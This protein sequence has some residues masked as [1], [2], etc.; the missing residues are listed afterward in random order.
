MP[1]AAM[2]CGIGEIWWRRLRNRRF[3]EM[4]EEESSVGFISLDLISVFKSSLFLVLSKS[5]CNRIFISFSES[6][7]IDNDKT[8]LIHFVFSFS[9]LQITLFVLEIVFLYARRLK[10]CWP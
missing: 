10:N 9:M 4:T 6:I 2:S 8:F 1:T 5:A 3:V 7:F